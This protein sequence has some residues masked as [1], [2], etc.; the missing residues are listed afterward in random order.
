MGGEPI[1][2][3][4]RIVVGRC[5]ASNVLFAGLAMAGTRRDKRRHDG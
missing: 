3:D 5:H 1:G 4:Q 2:G